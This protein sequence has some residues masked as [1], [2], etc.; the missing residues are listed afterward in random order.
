MN[1]RSDGMAALRRDT[2]KLVWLLSW[3]QTGDCHPLRV[4]SD[5]D[6]RGTLDGNFNG[7]QAFASPNHRSLRKESPSVDR[8]ID[9]LRAEISY[10]R[11]L[12]NSFSTGLTGVAAI[13]PVDMEFAMTPKTS[14]RLI[15]AAQAEQTHLE[16]QRGELLRRR[17]GLRQEFEAIEQDLYA[18][19]ERLHLLHRLAGEGLARETADEEVELRRVAATHYSEDVELE[20]LRGTAIRETAVRVLVERG[21][22]PIHYRDWH[23]LLRKAGYAVT[24]KDPQA[25]LLTQVSRSPVVR[26]TTSAG[27]YEIDRESPERLRRALANL[28]GQLRELTTAPGAPDDI[29]RVR[30][31]REE[32][33]NEISF[34]ER[35][36]EEADRVLAPPEPNR[37][38]SAAA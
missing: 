34:H 25:T 28:Q 32:L 36:L 16:T 23:E 9:R 19:D 4:P 20:L 6:R 10:A 2:Q 21:A 31:R 13:S 33:V 18:L 1:A 12:M 3:I 24:G 26:R 14:K 29:A 38:A 7:R 8:A 15:R 5:P 22:G 37:A 27:V 11:P 17:E 35:A 30:A